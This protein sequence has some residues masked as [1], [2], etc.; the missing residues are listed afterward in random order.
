MLKGFNINVFPKYQTEEKIELLSLSVDSIKDILEFASAEIPFSKRCVAKISG[1]GIMKFSKDEIV[2]IDRGVITFGIQLTDYDL[3]RMIS[4]NDNDKIIKIILPS[5]K[6]L[7]YEV[8]SEKS[9]ILVI[10]DG[11]I[12]AYEVLD[13]NEIHNKIKNDVIQE[14]YTK[15]NIDKVKNIIENKIA[16]LFSNTTEYKYIFE[17]VEE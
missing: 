5:V 1:K 11:F 16:S 9:Q 3:N 15:E 6:V 8:D 12:D 13:L 17:W 4:V 7:S 14:Y 2:V 10:E